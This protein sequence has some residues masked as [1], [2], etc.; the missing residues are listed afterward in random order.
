MHIKDK[1]KALAKML[2][3]KP[4][5]FGVEL[6][7]YGWAPVDDVLKGLKIN[8][9]FLTKI[10]DRDTEDR[11]SFNEDKSMCRAKQGHSIPDIDLNLTAVTPPD[12]LYHGTVKQFIHFIEESGLK[13]MKRHAVHLSANTKSAERVAGRRKSKTIILEIDAKQMFEDGYELFVT[14]NNVWLTDTVPAK[15]IKRI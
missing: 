4:E 14:E 7:S 11:Y 2:R 8:I 1:S 6:D 15:Y 5:D 12:I 13:K 3:H 10:I 9:K